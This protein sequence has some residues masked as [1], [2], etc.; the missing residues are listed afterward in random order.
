M[1]IKVWSND[2]GSRYKRIFLLERK[3]E[4]E[5]ANLYREWYNGNGYNSD[6]LP[7]QE[8]RR[9]NKGTGNNFFSVSRMDCIWSVKY[10]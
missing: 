5:I 4:M 10:A 1:Q 8:R 9:R 7:I 3:W 2:D 6:L